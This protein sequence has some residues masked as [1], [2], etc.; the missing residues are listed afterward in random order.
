MQ[1]PKKTRMLKLEK[2]DVS[3][4]IQALRDNGGLIGQSAAAL[5]V[6]R[7]SLSKFIKRFPSPELTEAIFHSRENFIDKCEQKLEK[8]VESNDPRIS[9][10]AVKFAL[11]TIGKER[12]YTTSSNIEIDANISAVAPDIAKIAEAAKKLDDIIDIEISED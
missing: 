11:S 4:I 2:V 8:H 6:D 1:M 12:G 9:L 5:G 7:A 3:V 10:D